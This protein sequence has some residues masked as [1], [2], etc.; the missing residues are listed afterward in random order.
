MTKKKMFIEKVAIPVFKFSGFKEKD[1]YVAL[2]SYAEELETKKSKSIFMAFDAVA[3]CIIDLEDEKNIK[4]IYL[5]N[6]REIFKDAK[7]I[8]ESFKSFNEYKDRDI[9]FKCL[10]IVHYPLYVE[11]DGYTVKGKDGDIISSPH[12]KWANYDARNDEKFSHRNMRVKGIE[13]AFELMYKRG[14]RR[15]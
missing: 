4:N 14:V 7:N 12:F 9:R 10:G 15:K 6:Y 13:K 1:M 8:K 2:H 5:N 11:D 3:L